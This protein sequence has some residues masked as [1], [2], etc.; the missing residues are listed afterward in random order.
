M[1]HGDIS[2]LK[3]GRKYFIKNNKVIVMNIKQII[4]LNEF[5]NIAL[6]SQIHK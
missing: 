2:K 3:N 6:T 4:I 1:Y 5:N